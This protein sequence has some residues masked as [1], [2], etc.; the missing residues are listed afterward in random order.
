M[1]VRD[2]INRDLIGYANDALFLSTSEKQALLR[3][4]SAAIRCYQTLVAISGQTANNPDADIANQ[5]N[6]FAED[7]DFRY[8]EETKTI[9]LEAVDAIRMLRLMLGIKQEIID[10]TL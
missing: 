9:M 10:G 6:K 8:A 5:L 1:R 2:G 4:A 3:E 7:I